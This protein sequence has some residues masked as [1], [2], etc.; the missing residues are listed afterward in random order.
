[1][2]VSFTKIDKLFCETTEQF[3]LV[4]SGLTM[5]ELHKLVEDNFHRRLV[6]VSFYPVCEAKAPAFMPGMKRA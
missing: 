6:D 3:E 2:E 1:M 5:R 4:V